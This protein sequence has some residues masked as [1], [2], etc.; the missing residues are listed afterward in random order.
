[1]VFL[2]DSDGSTLGPGK[3]QAPKS[4]LTPNSASPQT[5]ARAPN[6]AVLLTHCGH[7]ILSK[8]SKFDATRC[9]ILR[10]KCRKI[11]YRWGSGPDPM[12]ELSALPWAP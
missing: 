4:W 6:L 12:G 3:A 9:Q 10:L 8:I 2:G 5:V 11:N 7:P 1:M